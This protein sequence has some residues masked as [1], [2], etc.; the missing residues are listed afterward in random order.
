ME[1]SAGGIHVDYDVIGDGRPVVLLH[2]LPSTKKQMVDTFE[3]IFR[4]RHGWRRIYPDLPGMG[5]TPG[6][7]EISS[8]DSVLD[9][10]GQFVDTVAGSEPIVMIGS[11][12]GGYTA[13]GYNPAGGTGSQAS[14]CRNP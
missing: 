12:Y 7:P 14:C 13:L 9:V 10:V 8:Q 2:G 1:V 6:S 4:D 11:S 5:K 3:P